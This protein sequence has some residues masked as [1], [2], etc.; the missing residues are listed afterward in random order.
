MMD[1]I[2]DIAALAVTVALALYVIAKAVGVL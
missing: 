1:D 2:G